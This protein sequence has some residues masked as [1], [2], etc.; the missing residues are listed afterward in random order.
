MDLRKKVLSALKWTF[1]ARIVG[2]LTSWPR[3]V[4]Y[5][6]I[7]ALFVVAHAGVGTTVINNNYITV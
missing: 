5:I 1:A 4:S 6:D 3:S 7:D 2:Q